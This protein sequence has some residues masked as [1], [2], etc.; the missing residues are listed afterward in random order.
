M[1]IFT[2][3]KSRFGIRQQGQPGNSFLWDELGNPGEAELR[4]LLFAL[5][6]PSGVER[7]V[8]PLEPAM[9]SRLE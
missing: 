4:A 7:G 5:T 9:A 3:K 6:I 8:H 1:K 2:C